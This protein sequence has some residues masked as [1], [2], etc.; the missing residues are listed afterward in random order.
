MISSLIALA[1]AAGRGWQFEARVCWRCWMIGVNWE[2]GDLQG[3]YLHL[4]PFIVGAFR[5]TIKPELDSD[6]WI[7]RAVARIT[8]HPLHHECITVSSIDELLERS[9]SVEEA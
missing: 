5:W 2:R 1:G 8:A 4:G 9:R 6:F 7:D 3:F